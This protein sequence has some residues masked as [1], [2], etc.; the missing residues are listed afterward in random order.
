VLPVS[1]NLLILSGDGVRESILFSAG[2]NIGKQNEVMNLSPCIMYR[3]YILYISYCAS[4][5]AGASL[6][7]KK[8][9][10]KE[11]TCKIKSVSTVPICQTMCS[12]FHFLAFL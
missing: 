1:I 10:P 11:V 4:Q 2:A 7:D 5:V 12:H 8:G 6:K 3:M 9:K